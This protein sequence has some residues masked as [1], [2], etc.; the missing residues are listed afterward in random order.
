MGE[1]VS[2]VLSLWQEPFSN[3]KKYLQKYPQLEQ[4]K[5][6]AGLFAPGPHYYYIID[7]PTQKLEYVSGGTAQILGVDPGEVTIEFLIERLVPEHREKMLLKEEVVVDFFFNFLPASEVTN[8]KSVYYCS[9]RD[10]YDQPHRILHQA[11]PL[12][13]TSEQ[14]KPKH[15]LVVHTD[16]THLQPQL[17]DSLHFINLKQGKCYYDLSYEEG[18]FDPKTEP[19]V[20][21]DPFETL[22][23]R[24]MEVIQK[25]AEGFSTNE[26]AAQLHISVHTLRTHR[27]NIL[28]KSHCKNINELVAQYIRVGVI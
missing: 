16:V 25:I 13:L 2:K 17:K 22:T 18:Y 1:H 4:I 10:V 11:V 27:K 24:E 20:E 21:L 7:M 23:E 6:V 8:Y 12:S 26:I 5:K 9:I 14:L 19:E 15:V 3:D 28:K